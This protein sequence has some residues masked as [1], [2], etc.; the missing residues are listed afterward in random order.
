[1]V[2]VSALG[3]DVRQFSG[4]CPL[5]H[6]LFIQSQKAANLGRIQFHECSGVPG[7]STYA[8]LAQISKQP[9]DKREWMWRAAWN[10]EINFQLL[11]IV[12]GQ[13]IRALEYSSTDRAGTEKDH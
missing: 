13:L 9:A 4:T 6:G 8:R 12:P 2:A 10:V 5:A 7:F 3:I 1:I 11:Q